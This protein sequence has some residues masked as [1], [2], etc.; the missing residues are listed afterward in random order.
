MKVVV[1]AKVKLTEGV[2][3]L[4]DTMRVYA[5]AVQFCID[6]A[7]RQQLS[8][9]AQLQRRCYYDVK[10]R[11]GLQA[12]LVI[13]AITQAVE[14]VKAAHSKPEV[15]EELAI[16]YNFPRYASISH[17]WTRLSL[18]T[19]KGRVTFKLVIPKVF[20]PYLR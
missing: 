8:S 17:D 1:T 4:H 14:M 9:K 6:T 5:Q 18:S 16:R 12:Q 20:T 19:L 10:T 7:W 2:E 11:F 3:V 15:S 13:N